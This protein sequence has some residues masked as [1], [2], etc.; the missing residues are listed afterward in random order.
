[1]N[2]VDKCQRCNNQNAIFG[3]MNC[4]NFRLLCDRCDKYIHSLPGKTDHSRM[5]LTSQGEANYKSQ[6]NNSMYINNG[7]NDNEICNIKDKLNNSISYQKNPNINTSSVND[8][9]NNITMPQIQNNNLIEGFNNSYE[10]TERNTM[11]MENNSYRNM[12]RE[13]NNCFPSF[14]Y[15]SLYSKDYL[16]QLQVILKI[17]NLIVY[18]SKR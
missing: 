16:N 15:S 10:G 3:C 4:E 7:N 8:K 9:G 6:M 14:N 18:L 1:M 11:S 2:K 12:Q 17:F 13:I 5:A